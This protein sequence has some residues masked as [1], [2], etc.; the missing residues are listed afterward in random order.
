MPWNRESAWYA[1]F[2]GLFSRKAPFSVSGGREG[3]PS[4]RRIREAVTRSCL[5]NGLDRDFD[6]HLLADHHTAGLQRLIPGDAEVLTINFGGRAEPD[7]LAT[8][9]SAGQALE[10]DVQGDLTG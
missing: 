3:R 1:C 6:L 7:D 5:P 10:L 9:R 4:W 2:P 8:P